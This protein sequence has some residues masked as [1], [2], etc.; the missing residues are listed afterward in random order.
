M[1]KNRKAVQKATN[2]PPK[3]PK[4]EKP[5]RMKPYI[6]MVAKGGEFVTTSLNASAPRAAALEHLGA[7]A[8]GPCVFEDAEVIILS[9]VGGQGKIFEARPFQA[10]AEEE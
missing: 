3:A 4:P 7:D 2:S 8:V 10:V 5:K 9:D 1:P 6:A